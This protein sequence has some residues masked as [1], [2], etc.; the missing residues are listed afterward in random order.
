MKAMRTGQVIVTVLAVAHCRTREDATVTTDE[1]FEGRDVPARATDRAGQVAVPGT[2]ESEPVGAS[3][4]GATQTA[5]SGEA[6]A[7]ASAEPTMR[8]EDTQIAQVTEGVN[9]AEI[10]Q[11][12]LARSMSRNA[13]VL[14]FATMMIDHHGE[15]KRKQAQLKVS[16]Q[17]SALST[18]LAEEAKATLSRLRKTSGAEFDR[19]YLQAQV[20]GHQK[21]LDTLERDL[22]PQAEDA[23]LVSYLNELKPKVEHHLSQAKSDLEALA[24]PN[25]PNRAPDGTGSV[26]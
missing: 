21:V 11:A 24:K 22:I 17:P 16:P 9:S 14:A 7:S 4:P 26:P 25:G 5:P 2:T 19:A 10:E 18:K 13:K 3:E 20:D 23:Q 15:A 12:E 1:E 8:L 6:R